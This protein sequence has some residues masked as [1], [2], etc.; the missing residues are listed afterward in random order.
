MRIYTPKFVSKASTSFVYRGKR[1]E[2][3]DEF[4]HA[5]LKLNDV[6]IRGLWGANLIDFVT[7]A[8]APPAPPA[9]ATGQSAATA[10]K[11]N[12]NRR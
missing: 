2:A 12:G 11:P 3:G 9:S 8:P 7:P 5:E 4:P 1:F 10:T 6:E